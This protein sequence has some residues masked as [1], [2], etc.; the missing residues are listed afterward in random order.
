MELGRYGTLVSTNHDNIAQEWRIRDQISSSDK[1]GRGLAPEVP[2]KSRGLVLVYIVLKILKTEDSLI[3]CDSTDIHERN[4]NPSRRVSVSPSEETNSPLRNTRDQTRSLSTNR[5]PP[6]TIPIQYD[7]LDCL[8]VYVA[9]S[10]RTN[11]Y[12]PSWEA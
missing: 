8:C 3:F 11:L 7:P 6:Q 4:D 5:T 10:R 9:Y 2:T 12:T 1:D